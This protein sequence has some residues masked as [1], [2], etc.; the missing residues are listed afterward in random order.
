MF[1]LLNLPGIKLVDMYKESGALIFV[2]VAGNS[3]KFICPNCKIPMHRHGT[4]KNKFSDI[5]LY[6]EPVRLE[7][8]RPR[9]RCEICKKITIPELSFLDHKRRATKRL[10]DVIRQKC[11][12]TTLRSL[13]DQTGVSVNTVKNITHDLIQDLKQTVRYETPIIMGIDEVSLAGGYRCVITNLATNNLFEVLEECT[14]NHLK[15]YFKELPDREKVEWVCTGISPPI[16]RCF[17]EFFPNAKMVI[18]KFH[19]VKIASEALKEEQMKYQVQLSKDY[20]INVKKSI[21]WMTLKRPENLTPAEHKAIVRQ[22]IPELAFAY[23]CKESFFAIYNE[24]DKQHAQIAFEAWKK[25]LPDEGMEPFKRLV[26]TV[27]NHYDDIFAYWDAPF[28][29]TNTQTEGLNVL[30]KILNRLGRGY[31]YEIVRAKTLYSAEARKVG[32][33][34]RSGN[35]KVEY[36]PHIPTLLKQAEIRNLN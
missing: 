23:E 16:K 6:I 8:Q 5:P 25:S 7:V 3:E 9:F 28:P 34:I 26:K 21:R 11:L 36:G 32:S 22:Q 20:Q 2:A 1:D 24:P 31:S 10:V 14:Q 30:I 12:T 4:R 19:V 35:R 18:D 13:A 33:G 27:N 15:P 17:A 29:I